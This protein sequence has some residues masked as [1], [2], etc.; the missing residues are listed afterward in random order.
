MGAW[1]ILPFCGAE[2]LLL[3]YCLYTSMQRSS[4]CEVI[5]ITEK[6]VKIEK[7]RYKLEQRYEFIKGW[8]T[9]DLERPLIKGYPSRLSVRSQ[10]KQIEIGQFLVESERKALALELKKALA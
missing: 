9:I 6:W 8:T 7:G 10:G 5:T 1:L 4:V 2:L 3:G